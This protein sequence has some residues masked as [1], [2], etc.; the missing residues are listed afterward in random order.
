MDGEDFW[1][2]DSWWVWG[3]FGGNKMVLTLI[4]VMF[5]NSVSILKTTGLCTVNEWVGSYVG[6]YLNKADKEK[7]KGAKIIIPFIS[8][9][10]PPTWPVL[11]TMKDT[12]ITWT[13]CFPGVHV[14]WLQCMLEVSVAVHKYLIIQIKHIFSHI[15]QRNKNGD[16]HFSL[17][18]PLSKQLHR[19]SLC[20][21]DF[22]QI[23]SLFLILME[24]YTW[25]PS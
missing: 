23:K 10:N 13:S 3:F 12:Q 24:R 18:L 14:N 2:G 6:Y 16:Y 17:Q 9:I 8:P 7:N 15:T 5:H 22:Y 1:R 25:V 21:L 4:V 19:A 11:S 20:N